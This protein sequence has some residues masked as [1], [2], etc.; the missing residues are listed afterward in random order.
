MSGLGLPH[1]NGFVL[2]GT[3]S[4]A[5]NPIGEIGRGRMRVLRLRSW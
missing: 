3:E 1:M 4:R 2:R 5:A